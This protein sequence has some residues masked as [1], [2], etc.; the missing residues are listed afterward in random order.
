MRAARV[1]PFAVVLLAACAR[2][3]APEGHPAPMASAAP[4]APAAAAAPVGNPAA[5]FGQPI[6]GGATTSLVDIAKAPASY[7]GKVIA[8]EGTVTRV[9]Q[10]R[11]CWMAIKDDSGTATVRM[12]GHTFF[13]PTTSSGKHARVQGTVVLMKDGHE[14][15]E[16]EALDAKLELDATGVEL[17]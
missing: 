16:A 9:C 8:T 6:R 17:M 12:H 14:C 1:L 15:D 11:G 4:V 5:S 2:Q 13:V 7:R 3:P 10:E